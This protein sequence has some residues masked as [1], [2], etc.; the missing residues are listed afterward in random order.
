MASP[1]SGQLFGE[2]P[3]AAFRRSIRAVIREMARGLDRDSPAYIPEAMFVY[4][5]LTRFELT[6][7][8]LQFDRVHAKQIEYDGAR[9]REIHVPTVGKPVNLDL[10]P[11]RPIPEDPE[12]GPPAVREYAIVDGD[13]CLYV[14]LNGADAQSV[15]EATW[16]L[17]DW[18]ETDYER[19][20]DQ[21]DSIREEGVSTARRAY[22]RRTGDQF[23]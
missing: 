10:A 5:V 7:P 17:L 13:V 11:G 3:I 9:Y 20:R 12:E 22:R 15:E 23:G 2:R 14:K 1:G 21:I 18:V 8:H 19:V 16:A 4:G 6:L